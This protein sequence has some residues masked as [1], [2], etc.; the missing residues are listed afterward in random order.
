M[1]RGIMGIE[2]LNKQLPVLGF[3]EQ[4]GRGGRLGNLSLVIF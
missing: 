4:R 3:Y 1:H 2:T